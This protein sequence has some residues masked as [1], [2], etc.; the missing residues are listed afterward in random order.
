M[1]CVAFPLCSFIIDVGKRF[2]SPA[3]HSSAVCVYFVECAP[4]VKILQVEGLGRS[5]MFRTICVLMCHIAM[6]MK[7]TIFQF[8]LCIILLRPG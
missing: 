5:E 3:L 1:P 2:I 8:V 4:Y 7:T 6:R